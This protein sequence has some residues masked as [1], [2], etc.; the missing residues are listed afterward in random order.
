MKMKISKYMKIE[1][2]EEYEDDIQYIGG[3]CR[4][5]I[6]HIDEES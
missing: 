6:E 1:D 2:F 3:C 5:E 4:D